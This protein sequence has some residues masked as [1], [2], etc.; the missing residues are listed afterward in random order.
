M[1]RGSKMHE[2]SLPKLDK[3]LRVLVAKG[4]EALVQL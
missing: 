2:D 3:V 4:F 1:E